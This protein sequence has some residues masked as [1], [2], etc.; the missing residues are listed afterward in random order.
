M[1]GGCNEELAGCG[2]GAA[3]SRIWAVMWVEEGG[4]GIEKGALEMT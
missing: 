2:V 1:L 4:R 3:C